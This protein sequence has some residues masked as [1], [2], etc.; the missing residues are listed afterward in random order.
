MRRASP[1]TP[2]SSGIPRRCRHRPAPEPRSMRRPRC[3]A[4]ADALPAWSP[5]PSVQPPP[6]S[7]GVT[8][9]GGVPGVA[10]GV[11]GGRPRPA[12]EPP[13]GRKTPAAA[14]VG[15]VIGLAIIVALGAWFLLLR[16]GPNTALASPSP[17]AIVVVTPSPEATTTAEPTEQPTDEATPLATPIPTPFK[18]PTF[19]GKT[20]TEAQALAETGGLQLTIQYD[21]TTSQ[22]DG[23]VLSQAP[24]PG[25]SVLPGDEMS[26]VVAQ[27][28]TQCARAR[29]PGHR[30]SGCHQPAA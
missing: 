13:P 11:A 5:T 15:S 27:P 25:S 1:V 2:P 8:P 10:L 12:D 18:A 20:L 24:A 23:T 29:R 28:R 17:S 19:T 22:P 30:R 7:A 4:A 9:P 3:A 14:I 26:L 21:R 16:P 6:I